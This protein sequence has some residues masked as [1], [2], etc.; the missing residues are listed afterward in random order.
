M[1]G[2]DFSV[3]YSDEI[4]CGWIPKVLCLD[5]RMPIGRGNEQIPSESD[6]CCHGVWI[7]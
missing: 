5:S 1:V 7:T 4:R 3:E 6:A 2:P